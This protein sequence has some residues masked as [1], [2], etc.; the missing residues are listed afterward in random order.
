[1]PSIFLAHGAPTLVMEDNAYTRF[2]KTLGSKL[3]KPKAAVLFSAHW[4]SRVQMISAVPEYETIHD[5]F[6]FPDPLYEITYPAKGDI[7]L[8][9]QIERLFAD[10]GISSVLDD[11]RGLDH[12][13]WSLLRLMYPE[14]DVPVAALSVNPR[15]TPEEQYRIGRALAPLRECGALI[16]GSGGTVHNPDMLEWDS[17]QVKEWALTFDQWLAEQLETWNTEA[18]FD[19]EQRA[20][21]AGEAVPTPE[22]FAPVLLAMGAADGG[23]KA[24][25]LHRQ[26]Q[27]G[28]LSLSA[29]MFG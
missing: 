13:A 29:W 12:G 20:P 6:G 3:P 1:M 24:R 4:E 19:Y 26:Y 8:S 25:L 27:L 15:L 5:F 18:L 17:A 10:E 16:V 23:R 14:A 21:Y 9:L 2:L 11:R 7:A 28:T 22:H